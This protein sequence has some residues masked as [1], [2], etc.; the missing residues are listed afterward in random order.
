MCPLEN[1][2]IM[3]AMEKIEI[4]KSQ[5]FAVIGELKRMSSP[6]FPI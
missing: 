5:S 2:C 1:K 6:K 3:A 4:I